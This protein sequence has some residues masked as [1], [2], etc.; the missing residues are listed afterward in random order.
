MLVAVAQAVGLPGQQLPH[1]DDEVGLDHD[2]LV[3]ISLTTSG[4]VRVG[5]RRFRVGGRGN[6]RRVL[7]IEVRPLH[8]IEPQRARVQEVHEFGVGVEVL[9][10]LV[11]CRPG[12]TGVAQHHVVLVAQ[13]LRRG[14]PVR[15]RHQAV[16]TLTGLARRG[17][18]V[19]HAHV[20]VRRT[21]P[22]GVVVTVRIDRQQRD[23]IVGGEPLVSSRLNTGTPPSP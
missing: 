4:V 17:R 9:A 16:A 19:D 18:D 14:I 21:D 15:D 23:V 10:D 3:D 22:S 7:R 12:E 6:D 2:A 5:P 8:H 1:T 20:T 13:P 11:R